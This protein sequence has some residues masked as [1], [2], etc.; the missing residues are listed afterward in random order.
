[1]M[2]IA[3]VLLVLPAI[4]AEVKIIRTPNGGIQPQAAVDTNGVLHLIYFT[5]D[6]RAGDGFYVRRE[7]GETAFSTPV[8]INSDPG[9]V[10]AAG[11]VRGAHIALGRN[12][13]VHVAWM[14]SKGDHGKHPM[15]YTRLNDAGAA[16]E[17]QRNVVQFAY[18]LDG[19][20]SLAADQ[21]G[22]VVVAWH[23]GEHGKGE[24]QRRVWVARSTD[25]GRTFAREEPAFSEPTGACGCCGMRAF[26]ANSAVFMLY[27][28]AREKINRDMYLLASN[29]GGRSFRGERLHAWNIGACPMS[30]AHFAEGGGAAAAAW[31]TEWQV[32]FA[33]IDPRTLKSSAP[34]AAPG[35]TGKRKHPV[36]ARNHKGETLLVWTEG[37]GFRKGGSLAWQLFDKNGKPMGAPGEAP[38]VAASSLAAAV[39]ERDGNFTIV[40]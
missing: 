27:R 22:R 18:G 5:G 12:G 6:S 10:I 30:T 20:G 38:D 31:E 11:T 3:L 9:S 15:F 36:V 14:G 13:R 8:R 37:T 19:G 7:R 4:A 34:L 21:T 35:S 2:V 16:F 26:A 39:A 29:D 33:T 1:M 17:P 40:Y 23:A 28:S 32:Y 25:D 24:D